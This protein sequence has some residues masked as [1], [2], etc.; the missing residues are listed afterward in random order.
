MGPLGVAVSS[1]VVFLEVDFLE[2]DFLEVVLWVVPG[3]GFPGSDELSVS[4]ETVVDFPSGVE[5]EV[6]VVVTKGVNVS[7]PGPQVRSVR[8]TCPF[9]QQ[10]S[11]HTGSSASHATL[12]KFGGMQSTPV[13]QHPFIFV[14]GTYPSMLQTMS[15][16]LPP[17]VSKLQ[18]GSPCV[19]T[20]QLVP[21]GQ[22]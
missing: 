13:G 2:V 10:P 9:G 16:G 14:H 21:E 8:H 6:V 11:P 22:Q 18:L 5:E 4:D 12:Q 19:S 17:P 15:P 20:E 7:S 1:G 3:V